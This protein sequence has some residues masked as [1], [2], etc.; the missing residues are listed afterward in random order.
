MI[1]TKNLRALPDWKKLREACKA[2]AVLDA[3]LS[4]DWIY[5]YYSYDCQWSEN[6]ELFEMRNG[7]GG[8]MLILFREEGAVI[9]G[10]TSEMADSNK[11]ALTDQ[12]PAV[13]EEFIFGE[14]VSS[15]G[16][17]FCVWTTADGNWQTGV[18][19]LEEDYSEELLSA[20][21][22][23]PETYL[24][25]ASSYYEGIYAGSGIPLETVTHIFQHKPLTT[26]IV[27]SLVNKVE[28]WNQLK[29]DLTEISYQYH[30][31]D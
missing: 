14:P 29:E 8:Q 15:S 17:T 1:S 7:E 18:L 12:L 6:E 26:A 11:E 28:D 21:D 4:P 24:K 5:R 2:M 16:T 13:F 9:N 3:V 19:P 30:L 31:I 20:L 27:Y 23:Q 22:G 25:W 10:Y